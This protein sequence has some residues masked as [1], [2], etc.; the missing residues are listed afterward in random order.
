[1]DDYWANEPLPPGEYSFI[2]LRYSPR[3]EAEVGRMKAS[4]AALIEAAALL[5]LRLDQDANHALL[6]NAVERLQQA[7][8]QARTIDPNLID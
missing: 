6:L 5:L 1:M 4:H 3:R 7:T 8:D 2:G